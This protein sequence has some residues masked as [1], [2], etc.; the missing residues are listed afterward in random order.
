MLV[1]RNN[2]SAF[3]CS[4]PAVDS[5]MCPTVGMS[6][7]PTDFE[8][9][10]LFRFADTKMGAQIVEREV[11]PTTMHLPI[12][13]VCPGYNFDSCSDPGTVAFLSDSLDLYP[14]VSV[15]DCVLEQVWTLVTVR[16]EDI[17]V[18]V[19]VVIADS[20][21]TTDFFEC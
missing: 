12:L 16:D 17:Q 15:S 21:T 4:K 1:Y 18:P 7:G 2:F 13:D 11:T 14:I 6:A 10:N 5:E 20:S 19:V 9:F 3:N 8:E